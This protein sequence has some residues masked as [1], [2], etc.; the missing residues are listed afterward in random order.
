MLGWTDDIN[1][2]NATMYP[3]HIQN[4]SPAFVGVLYNIGHLWLRASIILPPQH[5][6]DPDSPCVSD[7][8]NYSTFRSKCTRY[9]PPGSPGSYVSRFKSHNSHMNFI[10]RL[11]KESTDIDTAF[12]MCAILL[13]FMAYISYVL[14]RQFHN[15]E[16]TVDI[17]TIRIRV[18]RELQWAFNFVHNSIVEDLPLLELITMQVYVQPRVIRTPAYVRTSIPSYDPHDSDISTAIPPYPYASNA[19]AARLDDNPMNPVLRYPEET[20]VARTGK[21]LRAVLFH[22][23]SPSRD[24]SRTVRIPHENIS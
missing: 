20:V 24:I 8:N 6:F 9:K 2:V 3:V 12:L 17:S 19:N 15:D 5:V 10:I 22:S 23:G 21:Q 1:I 7:R 16:I 13:D 18:W 4:S 14:S 11:R